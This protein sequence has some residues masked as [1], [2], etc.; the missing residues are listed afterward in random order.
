MTQAIQVRR[1]SESGYRAPSHGCPKRYHLKDG[2]RRGTV[3]TAAQRRA[4]G[5]TARPTAD[6]NIAADDRLGRRLIPAQYLHPADGHVADAEGMVDLSPLA[7]TPVRFMLKGARLI[8]SCDMP[9]INTLIDTRALKVAEGYE[10]ERYKYVLVDPAWNLRDVFD[11]WHDGEFRPGTLEGSDEYLRMRRACRIEGSVMPSPKALKGAFEVQR[12]SGN[13]GWTSLQAHFPM[14]PATKSVIRADMRARLKLVR[15]ENVVLPKGAALSHEELTMLEPVLVGLRTSCLAEK[16]AHHYRQPSQRLRKLL[17]QLDRTRTVGCIHAYGVLGAARRDETVQEY[18]TLLIRFERLA[19]RN[20]PDFDIRDSRMVARALNHIAFSPK[21]DGVIGKLRRYVI[22]RFVRIL[23]GRTRSFC[24]S[25]LSTPEVRAAAPALHADDTTFYSRLRERFADLRPQYRRNR[26]QRSDEIARR[27]ERIVDGA[28]FRAKQ[29]G[30]DGAA[31]RAAIDWM[32]KPENA[33]APFRQF[34][35]EDDEL[36]E[37]GLPTGRKLTKV[38]RCWRTE[39]AW[40]SLR[41]EGASVRDVGNQVHY[42]PKIVEARVSERPPPFVFELIE[43]MSADGEPPILPWYVVLTDA[44]ALTSPGR[45]TLDQRKRRHA[46]Q[47]SMVVPPYGVTPPGFVNFERDRST[48]ARIADALPSPRRF[49]PLE[50]LDLAVMMAAHKLDT[51]V[52]TWCRPHEADQQTAYLEDWKRRPEDVN[53]LDPEDEWGWYVRRKAD[54][55]RSAAIEEE[56]LVCSESLFVSGMRIVAVLR[57]RFFGGGAIPSVPAATAEWKL[58]PQPWIASGPNGAIA[59]CA[60]DHML[61]ILLAGIA[62]ATYHD[63]RHAG[64]ERANKA[65]VILTVIKAGLGQRSER[66]ARYY[67]RLILED[68]RARRTANAMLRRQENAEMRAQALM[69]ERLAA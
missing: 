29:M 23:I 14:T 11:R 66:L 49:I 57:R 17:W 28:A 53:E 32:S 67:S 52:Q 46:A 39:A 24:L 62:D 26:K 61:R 20:D 65:G 64:S 37:E 13:Y 22:C 58:Q 6:Y 44:L 47:C 27:Y 50:E 63:F 34:E 7:G 48:L 42:R 41:V 60:L 38:W 5:G 55:N 45:L 18:T 21:L 9:V 1:R 54:W 10:N 33:G 8:W 12:E 3:Q 69:F 19:R 35:V 31:G 25:P 4:S 2:K 56:F 59:P 43:V 36:D 30:A 40:I 51:V 16:N 68:R 15:D